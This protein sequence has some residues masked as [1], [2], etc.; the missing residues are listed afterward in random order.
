[1]LARAGFDEAGLGPTL[2]PLVVAGFATSV[3]AKPGASTDRGPVDDLLGPLASVVGPPGLRDGRLEVGDSKKIHTGTHKLARIERTALATVGWV[4]GQIP[5]SVS[6]L[7]ELVLVR[8]FELPEDRRAPWWSMLDEAL[9]IAGDRGRLEHDAGRLREVADARGVTPLWYRADVVSAARVNREL[10]AEQLREGT[11]NTWATHAVLRL[12]KHAVDRIDAH[13]IA[14]WCDKAGGRQAYLEPL[15]RV[16]PEPTGRI[17]VLL[18]RRD[19]SQYGLLGLAP[20]PI[21]VGFVMGGDRLDPRISWGSILAKYLRE[22]ILRAFNRYFVARVMELR[23][24][25][26]YPED[27]KRFIAQVQLSLGDNGGLERDAWIRCK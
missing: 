24:T 2:G 9:P 21:E 7:L 6:E 4:Y 27:A 20:R 13:T 1:M 25:A 5:R 3:Q 15:C 18:E 17:D 14:L 23:P 10:A 26:G 12:A 16:W 8:E 19:R 11:K 22:L